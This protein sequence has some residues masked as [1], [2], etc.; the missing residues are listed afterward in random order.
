MERNLKVLLAEDNLDLCEI[1]VLL[2]GSRGHVVT[3][4]TNGEEA[5]DYLRKGNVPDIL[6]TDQQ[7]PGMTGVQLIQ[8]VRDDKGDERLRGMGC[9][10]YSSACLTTDGENEDDLCT[11]LQ[12]IFLPKPLRIIPLEQAMRRALE[13]V[14]GEN[15]QAKAS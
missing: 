1:A 4:V 8:R 11:S 14:T 10:L 7:M 2:L 13:L 6:L 15:S 9:V 12:A 5:W 3:A